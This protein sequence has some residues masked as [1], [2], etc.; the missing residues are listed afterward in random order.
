MV[1]NEENKD[2]LTKFDLLSPYWSDFD[3][4]KIEFEKWTWRNLIFGLFQT[5]IL[6]ATQ[7]VK[8]KFQIDQTSLTNPNITPQ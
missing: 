3:F 4:W 1:N 2:A 8:I 5:W 7:T 6:Q